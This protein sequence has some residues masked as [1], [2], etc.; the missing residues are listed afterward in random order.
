MADLIQMTME[1]MIPELEE[2]QKNQIFSKPEIQ[3]IVQ[4]RKDFEYK[5]RRRPMRQMDG[6]RYIEYELNLETLSKLRKER[7]GMSE[8]KP[9]H[10]IIR[11]V[12]HIFDRMIQKFHGN[13]QLWFQYI[14][15]CRQDSP[16]RCSK[17]FS[18]CLQLHPRN[19]SLWIEAANW[20]FE[21]NNVRSAR[22]LL[23]RAIRL[24]PDCRKLWQ[25]YFRL[26]LLFLQ[27]ITARRQVLGL[28]APAQEPEEEEEVTKEAGEE[29][30]IQLPTLAGETTKDMT[31]GDDDSELN[32]FQSAFL[33]G[34]IPVIV[35]Q[36]AVTA[37]RSEDASSVAF[38][39]KFLE[40][41]NLFPMDFSLPVRQVLTA[42]LQKRFPHDAT[43]FRVIATSGSLSTSPSEDGGLSQ[44]AL[45]QCIQRF[46]DQISKVHDRVILATF[47]LEYVSW[48]ESQFQ[49]LH[50]SSP[51]TTMSQQQRM[52]FQQLQTIWDKLQQQ[53]ISGPVL[54]MKW[55]DFV[56]RHQGMKNAL[57]LL[58]QACEEYPHEMEFWLLKAD[59]LIS[60]QEPQQVLPLLYQSFKTCVKCSKEDR[61]RLY[62]NLFR[63]ENNMESIPRL[64][65]QA[66]SE[67]Q[68]DAQFL[69]E[70]QEQY[71]EWTLGHH[72]VDAT[73]TLYQRFLQGQMLHSDATLRLLQYCLQFEY[74]RC[75]GDHQ[76]AR[77]GESR[78]QNIFERSLK[79]FGQHHVQMWI[80]YICFYRERRQYEEANVIQRR[81]Q[82]ILSP[83]AAAE[84]TLQLS[85]LP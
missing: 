33:N 85:S 55:I 17:I 47:Y 31:N 43:A 26:E 79:L 4:R 27:K 76:Q 41:A 66:L 58:D 15:F 20:E 29:D 53:S 68:A 78:V 7:L 74:G 25:E 56:L 59:V 72:G 34:K 52:V 62:E 75:D 65:D 10:F 23:Q 6:L 51:D 32:S 83:D 12:H 8:A 11:R 73:R 2:Y 45:R 49:A 70:F 18:R 54:R 61:F 1:D 84:F 71:L 28:P 40:I 77:H 24:N 42:S 82:R 81:A 5:L 36:N 48:L 80:D 38:H 14:Q 21:R 39:L 60:S 63:F 69:I 44:D 22:I 3:Q 19:T 64:F 50:A 16:R 57:E 35:Y 67:F 13:I 37:V 9:Y 30:A 46:E